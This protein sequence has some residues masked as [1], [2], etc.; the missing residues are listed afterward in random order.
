MFFSEG[1][2]LWIIGGG[3]FV[4]LNG[5]VLDFDENIFVVDCSNYRINKFDRYGKYFG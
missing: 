4:F 1:I 3:E 2:Y 5:I